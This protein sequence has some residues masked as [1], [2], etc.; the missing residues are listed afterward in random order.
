VKQAAQEGRPVD[1]TRFEQT[2]WK[3]WPGELETWLMAIALR[4]TLLAPFTVEGVTLYQQV[5][6]DSHLILNSERALLPVK[7]ILFPPSERLFSIQKTGQQVHLEESFPGWETV[8]FGVRPCEARGAQVL[9]AIFLESEPA[10]PFYARRRENTTLIGLACSEPGP[11]CFCTSLGGAPDDPRGM[12]IMLYLAGEEYLVQVLTEK[13]HF[14]IPA[15]EWKATTLKPAHLDGSVRFP[16]PQKEAW[17]RHFKDEYWARIGERCLSCRA[18]AYVCPT[19]RCFA[20]RDEA[21]GPGEFERLRCWD[22][23]MGENYRRVAGGH[24]PRVKRGER[25]R[26]RFFCK[27]YYAPEQYSLGNA[28]ACTGCG[29]CIDV[30]PVGVDITEILADLERQP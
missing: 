25:Q 17:P 9:D 16:V 30:C 28:P 6:K 13:G 15:G 1:Q 4:R 5:K 11:S 23:C 26:N 22:S 12:D 29:R 8:V 19:C 18:C 21:L 24:K 10:D 20:V 3:V 14:L 7:S 2:C 27:F